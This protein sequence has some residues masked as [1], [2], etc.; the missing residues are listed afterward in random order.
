MQPIGSREATVE[1][2]LERE[3][4]AR[5]PLAR[6]LR[7]EGL[8]THEQVEQALAEGERTGERL[9]EILLRWKVMDDRQLALQLARQWQLPFL[10]EHEVTPDASAL[11][12]LVGDARRTRAVPVRCEDGLVRVAVAEPTDERL[13]EARAR[14]SQDVGFAVVTLGTFQQLLARIEDAPTGAGDEVAEAPQGPSAGAPSR[15]FDALLGLLDDETARLEALRERVERFARA[16]AERDQ[17]VRRLE[18]ELDAARI[19]REQ[20]RLAVN[21]LQGEIHERD[22]LLDLVGGKVEELASTLRAGRA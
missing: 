9:G 15:D 2:P 1:R 13:A 4:P 10:D 22:R 5:P 8:V 17:V 12:G 20:D 21:R 19:A 6:L 7:E 11:A 3:A 14:A 16:V 18:T